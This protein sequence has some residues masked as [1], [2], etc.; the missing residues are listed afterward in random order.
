MSL[1]A[2]EIECVSEPTERCIKYN[3]QESCVKEEVFCL[4]PEQVCS[5]ET[6]VCVEWEEVCVS[7]SSELNT[8]GSSKCLEFRKS[9]VESV[10]TCSQWKHICNSDT[11]TV[12]L[13]DRIK[14]FLRNIL[15]KLL[16]N[17]FI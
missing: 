11:F 12:C 16:N 3:S 8:D 14:F 17:L 9:C 13:V 6:K 5:Q 2:R 1:C 7:M 10:S 4:H 15:I